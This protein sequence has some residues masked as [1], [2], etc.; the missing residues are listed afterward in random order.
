MEAYMKNDTSWTVKTWTL[1][2]IFSIYL[3]KTKKFR[4]KRTKR[5]FF[6]RFNSEEKNIFNFFLKLWAKRYFFVLFNSRGKKISAEADHS[7]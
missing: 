2:P 3:V 7:P 5:L 4:S 6:V 1:L